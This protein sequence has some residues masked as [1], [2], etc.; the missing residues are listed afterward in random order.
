MRN[1]KRI[2]YELVEPEIL[3]KD[4]SYEFRAIVAKADINECIEMGE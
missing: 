4:M 2:I 3:R 1:T